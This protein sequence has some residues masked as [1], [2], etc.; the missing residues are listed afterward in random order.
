MVEQLQHAMQLNYE[1]WYYTP[2]YK[3]FC[4]ASE[5]FAV[6]LLLYKASNHKLNT[7]NSAG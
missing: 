7:K 4:I 3:L 1:N 5:G 6:F 2:S